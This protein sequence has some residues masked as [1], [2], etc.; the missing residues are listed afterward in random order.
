MDKKVFT[1]LSISY[2]SIIYLREKHVVSSNLFSV[3]KSFS[4]FCFAWTDINEYSVRNKVNSI[5]NWRRQKSKIS[6]L[7]QDQLNTKEV[8]A[9]NPTHGNFF[10]NK[11]VFEACA[12]LENIDKDF[13]DS[14]TIIL[15]LIY[16][17]LPLIL[18]SL[19]TRSEFTFCVV[20]CTSKLSQSV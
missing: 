11:E 18:I 16:F 15:Y 3:T 5:K 6:Y 12:T 14:C 2:T 19:Q 1:S 8:P 13:S 10:F 20:L 7:R 17:F 4:V 9:Q